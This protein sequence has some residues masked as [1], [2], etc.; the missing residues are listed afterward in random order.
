MHIR[1]GREEIVTEITKY[2][3]SLLLLLLWQHVHFANQ[4]SL[5]LFN[6]LWKTERKVKLQVWGE[7]MRTNWT[8]EL[9]H[10]SDLHNS[11]G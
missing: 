11:Q 10:I 5:R 3:F 8:F 2:A 7:K 9:I 1:V 6:Y 4:S